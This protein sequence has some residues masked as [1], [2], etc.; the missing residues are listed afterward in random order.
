MSFQPTCWLVA[1]TSFARQSRFSRVACCDF[2]RFIAKLALLSNFELH[3]VRLCQ[4]V[5]K[6]F[7]V[8]THHGESSATSHPLYHSACGTLSTTSTHC[9]HSF[10]TDH[11]RLLVQFQFT[12]GHSPSDYSKLNMTFGHLQFLR[13]D[14]LSL[15]PKRMVLMHMRY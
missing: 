3:L 15:R 14:V 5:S 4:N 2:G 6:V 13:A 8:S 9:K 1:Y 12:R 10:T 7:P 11:T